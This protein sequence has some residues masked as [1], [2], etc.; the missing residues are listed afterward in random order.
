MS[1]GKLPNTEQKNQQV[2]RTQELFK[3]G[4]RVRQEEKA[5]GR[6]EQDQRSWGR[7]RHEGEVLWHV[8]HA[9]PK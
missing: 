9:E 8:I 2:T 3:D 1:C 5:M 4:E 6:R 7:E